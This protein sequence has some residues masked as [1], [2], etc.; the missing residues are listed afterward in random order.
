MTGLGLGLSL[1]GGGGGNPVLA[2]FNPGDDGFLRDPRSSLI[3]SDSGAST[4]AV[5][6]GPVRWFYDQF[7][8][9]HVSSASDAARATLRASGGL[10]YIEFNGSTS[11]LQGL[12]ST[13]VLSANHT[14]VVCF[15]TGVTENATFCGLRATASGNDYSRF[16]AN[17]TDLTRGL[18]RFSTDGIAVTVTS[19]ATG[20]SPGTPYVFTKKLEE[21]PGNLSLQINNDA[22]IT[23]ASNWLG[24]TATAADTTI[25]CGPVSATQLAGS[26]VYYHFYINR[27]LSNDELALVKNAARIA[28]GIAAW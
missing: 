26:K 28:G 15:D 8:D 27:I 14:E 22:E 11:L 16:Q 2:L 21:S 9:R 3:F 17:V 25:N 18:S 7:S 10:K 13:L 20:I 23:S 6:N 5:V 24:S 1:S 12:N 19:Y 4:P